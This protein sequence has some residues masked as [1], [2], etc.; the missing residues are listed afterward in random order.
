MASLQHLPTEL[1]AVVLGYLE[2]PSLCNVACVSQTLNEA[3][4]NDALWKPFV[5]SMHKLGQT[6]KETVFQLKQGERWLESWQGATPEKAAIWEVLRPEH[7]CVC[8]SGDNIFLGS[9]NSLN[10]A[11]PPFK[12]NS[13]PVPACKEWDF[14]PVTSI[15]THDT[16]LAV[17]CAGSATSVSGDAYVVLFDTEKMQVVKKFTYANASVQKIGST[18]QNNRVSCVKFAAEGKLV[19]ASSV[20]DKCDGVQLWNVE[21]GE[22]IAGFNHRDN[23]GEVTLEPALYGVRGRDEIHGLLPTEDGKMFLSSSYRLLYQWDVPSRTLLRKIEFYPPLSVLPQEGSFW[24]NQESAY[25]LHMLGFSNPSRTL[26]TVVGTRKSKVVTYE[27]PSM[28]EAKIPKEFT[29]Q[30][31]MQAMH[32]TPWRTVGVDV[33]GSVYLWDSNIRGTPLNIGYQIGVHS[34]GANGIFLDPSTHAIAW[35]ASNPQSGWNGMVGGFAT[36]DDMKEWD[37]KKETTSRKASN[38]KSD[39]EG[40]TCCVQ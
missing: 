12:W 5:G 3:S 26:V 24:M 32:I 7:H 20:G 29:L 10:V 4:G 16:M 27:W 1:L 11:Q 21:T 35:S 13:P 9:N 40:R 34:S 39:S 17:G 23:G 18:W 19:F 38:K 15:D 37:L 33:Y 8:I 22:L 2:L 14:G 25:P 31:E 30:S 28:E 36:I 6:W